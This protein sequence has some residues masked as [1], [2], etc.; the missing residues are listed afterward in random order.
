MRIQKKHILIVLAIL[1]VALGV[2]SSVSSYVYKGTGFSHS[3]PAS[4]YSGMSTDDILSNYSDTDCN[5]EVSG[6]CTKVVDGDTIYVDG[7]GKIRLVGVNT[8]EKGAGGY[9][10]SKEF[11]TKLCKGKTVGL[12]IDNSKNND[13]YNRTLAVVIVDGKNLNEMLLKE[14]LAEVMYIPPSEFNPNQWT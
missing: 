11:V 7:V 5:V 14:G 4:K 6:V 12:D 10:V 2:M 8:P 9:D 3:V 13:K 1:I